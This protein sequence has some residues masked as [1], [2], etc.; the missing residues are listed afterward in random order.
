MNSPARDHL[1]ERLSHI[2]L[3]F[4]AACRQR[5]HRCSKAHGRRWMKANRLHA[6]IPKRPL[7]VG[8]L[9]VCLSSRMRL[10]ACMYTCLPACLPGWLSVRLSVFLDVCA[11]V[12]RQCATVCMSVC[13]CPAPIRPSIRRSGMTVWSVWLGHDVMPGPA[14]RPMPYH[15]AMPPMR[16]GPPH[17]PCGHAMS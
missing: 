6:C 15:D 17:G 3:T 14:M 10:N 7:A 1:S 11:R 16:H 12:W 5:R 13:V 4:A 8:L 9:S 2:Y